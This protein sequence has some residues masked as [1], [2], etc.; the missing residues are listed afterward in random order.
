MNC[1]RGKYVCGMQTRITIPLA[2]CNRLVFIEQTLPLFSPHPLQ[3]MS[4]LI[5]KA[6]ATPACILSVMEA[7]LGE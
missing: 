7:G 2:A 1:H 5:I 3:V 6:I 4:Q